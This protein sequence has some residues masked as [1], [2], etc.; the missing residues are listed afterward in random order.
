MPQATLARHDQQIIDLYKRMEELESQGIPRALER[1]ATI[2][3]IECERNKERD[4]LN[5]RQSETLE[6][7]N[8]NLTMMNHKIDTTIEENIR[9]NDKLT[10]TN[11]RIKCLEEQVEISER[12]NI[13]DW[14][15][16]MVKVMYAAIPAG[17][18]YLVT[19][20]LLK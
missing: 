20:G 2:S 17:L 5:K 16:V 7:I 19:T 18:T 6:N 9:T 4:D 10:Q 1:L 14:R 3:G 8:Q 12:K 13:I 11:A 15:D